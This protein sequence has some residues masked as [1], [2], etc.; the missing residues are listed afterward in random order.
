MNRRVLAF[1]LLACQGETGQGKCQ[2]NLNCNRQVIWCPW[3]IEKYSRRH[4]IHSHL[5]KI[6]KNSTPSNFQHIFLHQVVDSFSITIRHWRSK[7]LGVFLF[8]LGRVRELLRDLFPR[9]PW[10]VSNI[11]LCSIPSTNFQGYRQSHESGTDSL[12]TG[13]G[14]LA[15]IILQ[16]SFSETRWSKKDPN[17]K[18]KFR[19]SVLFPGLFQQIS[20]HSSPKK[21]PTSFNHS[22]PET[23]RR[24]DSAPNWVP[25]PSYKWF[26]LDNHHPPDRKPMVNSQPVKQLHH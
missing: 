8:L 5:K 11:K 20:S 23:G 14:D 12:G 7:C 21:N 6:F 17:L 15:R 26:Q 13:S 9:W 2:L 24:D 1:L 3:I 19:L 16:F 10:Q 18:L 25:K 22:P 4:A